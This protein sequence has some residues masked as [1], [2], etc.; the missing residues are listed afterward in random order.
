MNGLEDGRTFGAINETGR[1][2][3][4]RPAALNVG[5]C[6]ASL[7]EGAAAIYGSAPRGEAFPTRVRGNPEAPTS[8]ANVGFTDPS[9]HASDRLA[10]WPRRLP[11]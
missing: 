9:R 6:G 5:R 10:A 2:Y 8:S 1:R 4:D 11:V 3:A 7:L